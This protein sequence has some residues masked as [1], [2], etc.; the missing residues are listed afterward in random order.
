[1]IKTVIVFL[2][3]ILNNDNTIELNSNIVEAC[4]NQLEFTTNMNQKILNKEIQHWEAS[5][6]NVRMKQRDKGLAL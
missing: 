6:F 4:P 5:C 2:V 1:M 3:V